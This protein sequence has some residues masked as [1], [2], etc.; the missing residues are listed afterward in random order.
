M[1]QSHVLH[2]FQLTILH[3]DIGTNS[4]P[5]PDEGQ[6][7]PLQSLCP[8]CVEKTYLVADSPLHDGSPDR[9][10]YIACEWMPLLAPTL[11]MFEAGYRWQYR[12]SANHTL[13]E[14]T[15]DVN[16]HLR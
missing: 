13:P 1:K 7:V 6:S 11:Y 3:T 10:R 2:A 4:I 9:D 12:G 15:Y 8:G 16:A 5:G 14:S